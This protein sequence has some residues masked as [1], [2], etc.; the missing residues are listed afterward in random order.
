MPVDDG[1][2]YIKYAGVNFTEDV[3]VVFGGRHGRCYFKGLELGHAWETWNSIQSLY[4]H[5]HSN[6]SEKFND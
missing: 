1:A 3:T 4:S 2:E 5:V 6:P